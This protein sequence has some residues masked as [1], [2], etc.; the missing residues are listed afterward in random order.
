[1]PHFGQITVP[2]VGPG[3]GSLDRGT[4]LRGGTIPGMDG[5][6]MVVGMLAEGE[7]TTGC[8]AGAVARATTALPVVRGE[9]ATKTPAAAA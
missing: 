8:E 1:L 9:G 4:S 7:T 3:V 6:S 5:P 2:G